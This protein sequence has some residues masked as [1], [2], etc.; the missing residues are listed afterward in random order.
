MNFDGVQGKDPLVSPSP[1]DK[2]PKDVIPHGDF[3]SITPEQLQLVLSFLSDNDLQKV[4]RLDEYTRQNVIR[5]GYDRKYVPL[6]KILQTITKALTEI[7]RESTNS[8]VKEKFEKA[9]ANLNSITKTTF[10]EI[11]SLKD[12]KKTAFE[13]RQTII[14]IL[15]SLPFEEQLSLPYNEQALTHLNERLNQGVNSND[16]LKNLALNLQILVK[17]LNHGLIRE[18]LQKGGLKNL[19]TLIEDF[20]PVI[21]NRDPE[22]V[23]TTSLATEILNSFENELDRHALSTLKQIPISEKYDNLRLKIWQKL[24]RS[25]NLNP[26]TA[27]VIATQFSNEDT[28]NERKAEI[29]IALAF[30]N[31]ID[32]ALKIANS[33]PPETKLIIEKK[34]Y[35][36]SYHVDTEKIHLGDCKNSIL[37]ACC[38]NLLT[39]EPFDSKKFIDLYSQMSPDQ[40]LERFNNAL[41]D[42]VKRQFHYLEE[43]Q[44]LL[45]INLISLPITTE[46]MKKLFTFELFSKGPFR[47][48]LVENLEKKL[49]EI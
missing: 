19:E 29:G 35:A 15:L 27:L 10:G 37:Y 11:T 4:A 25:Q 18:D 30:A 46:N 9:I 39:Q 48:K 3:A 5:T 42:L 2:P 41:I 23:S 1:T 24:D 17:A 33:F 6:S 12:V 43:P 26:E 28:R 45:I 14:K 47:R 36:E 40:F 21:V 34:I 44:I 49:N 32:D 20:L 31:K 22:G 8:E 38:M 7:S 16:W 13:L